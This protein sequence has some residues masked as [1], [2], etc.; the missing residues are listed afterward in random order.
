[1]DRK[2]SSGEGMWP[3]VPVTSISEV[4]M[5]LAS[6]FDQA[7]LKGRE[8]ICEISQA[9][10]RR[11][12]SIISTQLLEEWLAEGYRFSPKMEYDE[13][14]ESWQVFLDEISIYTWADDKATAAEQALD[15]ALDYARDYLD[16]LDL[17]LKIPDRRRHYPYLLRLAHATTREEARKVLGL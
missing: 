1:M 2:D 6:L 15:L 17:F 11:R 3:M 12:A 5:Q 7:A 4:P 9:S 13:P 10:G 14:T 16:R 8:V